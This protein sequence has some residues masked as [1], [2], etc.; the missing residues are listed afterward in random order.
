MAV[1]AEKALDLVHQYPYLGVVEHG[2]MVNEQPSFQSVEE[3]EHVADI[4]RLVTASFDQ[5][6]Q[7]SS[8]SALVQTVVRRPV[9]HR[10]PGPVGAVPA[11]RQARIDKAWLDLLP[12]HRSGTAADVEHPTRDRAAINHDA[13]T[14]GNPG[15]S[16]PFRPHHRRC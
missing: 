15:R 14:G 5:P 16:T 7:V 12:V 10:V 11:N 6:R 4:G 3:Q 8:P 1:H 13:P 2:A 9:A